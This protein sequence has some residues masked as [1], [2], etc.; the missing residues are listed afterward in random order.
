LWRRDRRGSCR[1]P[2][3]WRRAS[4]DERQVAILWGVAAA[5]ALVL[6]PLWLAIAPLLPACPFRSLTGVPCVSC[7]STHAALALLDGR[8][9]A[10]LAFNPLAAAAAL[11]FLA[12]G[13]TAPFWAL[14][15]LRL[16]PLPACLSPWA[17][18]SIVLAL[19]ADWVWVV[20]TAS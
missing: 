13:L 10:A 11:A 19:V 15:R 17:R 20:L 12:G 3:R 7:G 18:V 14:L 4:P 2:V 9:G 1:P 8:L 16:P 6:R 5:L